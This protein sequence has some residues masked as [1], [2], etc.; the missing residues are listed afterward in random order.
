M[1][2][3]GGPASPRLRRVNKLV[4]YEQTKGMA[5][6]SSCPTSHHGG[7]WKA[8]LGLRSGCLLDGQ[9]KGAGEVDGH[10]VSGADVFWMVALVWVS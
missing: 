9:M 3:A 1:L 8:P 6:A 4:P 7:R 5:G 2:G 10:L